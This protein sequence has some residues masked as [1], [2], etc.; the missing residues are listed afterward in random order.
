MNK[1][2][3]FYRGSLVSEF[4]DEIKLIVKHF[5]EDS[6]L[7]E[8]LDEEVYLFLEDNRL[9]KNIEVSLSELDFFFR[10]PCVLIRSKEELDKVK[11]P[12]SEEELLHWSN[13]VLLSKISSKYSSFTI[14]H[15]YEYDLLFMCSE[16]QSIF[17]L[18]Q[19]E[20]IIGKMGLTNVL[21]GIGIT[22]ENLNQSINLITQ[23][24]KKEGLEV[25]FPIP[26]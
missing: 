14:I 23:T 12:I 22:R 25:I 13:Y 4:L 20:K 7:I 10:K 16:D 26:S 5:K 18:I 2:Y 21:K 3:A 1:H 11:F 17:S 9:K 6:I 19:V 8:I 24:L 15:F